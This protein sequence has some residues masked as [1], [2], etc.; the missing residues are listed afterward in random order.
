MSWAWITAQSL[1]TSHY[2]GG[3]RCQDALRCTATCDNSV[4]V[5]TICDGA[6]TA[7]FGGQGA[8]LVCRNWTQRARAFTQ[9]NGH[10]LPSGEIALQWLEEA[11]ELVQRASNIRQRQPRDF[12]TTFLAVIANPK[13]TAVFAVG[14]G[15]AVLRHATDHEWQVPLWP[16]QGEYASSTYF[17]TDAAPIRLRVVHLEEVFD[18]VVAFTDGLERLA[19]NHA[20]RQAYVP[21]LEPITQPLR[22]A[23]GSGKLQGLSKKLASFL[24]SSAVNERT[25]DDKSLII[26]VWR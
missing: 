2:R 5:A 26:A 15:A 10:T 3:D 17:V 19:L 20:N 7:S 21:F 18:A 9:A 23:E 11:R 14:D 12:A 16:E 8:M 24:G 13:R 1:G 6:G 22:A 25:D 4:L